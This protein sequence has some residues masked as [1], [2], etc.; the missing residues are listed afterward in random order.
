MNAAYL[1]LKT[2]GS[3]YGKPPRSLSAEEMSQARRLADRQSRLERQVLASPEARDVAVPAAT[4]AAA[5]AEIRGRYADEA[6]LLAD[7][8]DNGLDLAAFTDALERELRAQAVLDRVGARAARVSDIDVELYYH[9]HPEQ[10]TRPETRRVRHILVTI[11]A[12]LADNT[13]EVAR[14]RIEAIAARLARDPDRFEEQALK[15]SECPTAMQGGLLGE[16]PR[17]TL[18]PE[19]DA[20][21]FDLAPGQLSGV[22][23]SPLGWHILLCEAVTP[24]H[25]LGLDEVRGAIR[26]NL[27]TRRKGTCQRSWLKSLDQRGGAEPV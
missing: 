15:H 24:A 26:D 23:E 21:L 12:D 5:L 18:Y 7:L 10:F 16:A 20:V 27:E 11:N 2:A 6:A 17:G 8:A 14:A 9:Y 25:T 1:V 22:V 4:L 3:L 13:R 19:L